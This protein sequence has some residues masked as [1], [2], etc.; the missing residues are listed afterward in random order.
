MNPN[1]YNSQRLISVPSC[2]GGLIKQD[3]SKSTEKDHPHHKGRVL[4]RCA[5]VNIPS[6]LAKNA[7]KKQNVKS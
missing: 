1:L 6:D 4:S 7:T 2:I 3:L 5:I